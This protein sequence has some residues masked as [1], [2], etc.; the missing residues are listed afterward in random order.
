MVP[1]LLLM[2]AAVM[3]RAQDGPVYPDGSIRLVG[4]RNPTEGNVEVFYRGRWGSICDDE[5]DIR[6]AYIVCKM[7]GYNRAVRATFNSQFG[8]GR[9]QGNDQKRLKEKNRYFSSLSGTC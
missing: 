4:G 1:T 2:L 6:E 9:A 3:V 8:R 5:W 7:L